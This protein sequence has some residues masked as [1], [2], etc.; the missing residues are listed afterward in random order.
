MDEMKEES[1]KIVENTR[2][3]SVGLKQKMEALNPLF[4]SIAT[5]GDVLDYKAEVF[6]QKTL[7]AC[8]RCEKEE[9]LNSSQQTTKEEEL[10]RKIK[11]HS[12]SDPSLVAEI[13]ELA[14]LGLR[15]WQNL[16]IRR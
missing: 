7:R 13:F 4:Q 3:I 1:K 12:L 6:R 11:E 16:K 15:L 10:T 5:L 14:S 2:E 9:M 8:N